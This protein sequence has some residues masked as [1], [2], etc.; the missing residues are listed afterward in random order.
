MSKAQKAFD[1]DLVSSL[2]KYDEKTGLFYWKKRPH[3]NSR[4][5]AGDAAGTVLKDGYIMIRILKRGLLAHR[6]AWS[7]YYGNVPEGQI[8]H[9]NGNKSDNRIS[10]LRVVSVSENAQNK[11][12]PL[13][14][15]KNG[16][17][18]VSR[19]KNGK[20]R[21]TINIGGKNV[22]LGSF[23]SAEKASEAYQSAKKKHHI[24]Q[25]EAA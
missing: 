23:E 22:Y 21:A 11:R 15:N 8:D 19:F 5:R 3:N 18:G 14:R 12:N 24:A 9:I 10:N 7:I 25:H 4:M 1:V 20:Y 2:I 6:V 13:S 17:L 16:C